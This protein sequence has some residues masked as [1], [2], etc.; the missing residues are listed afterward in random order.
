MQQ[1][2]DEMA[3][4][5]LAKKMNLLVQGKGAAAEQVARAI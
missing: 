5:F 4:F 1:L 3:D 2:A